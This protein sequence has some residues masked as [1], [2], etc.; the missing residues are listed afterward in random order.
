MFSY[1]FFTFIDFLFLFSFLFFRIYFVALL[2]NYLVNVIF[3]FF[4]QFFKNL[5]LNVYKLYKMFFSFKVTTKYWLYSPRY[6]TYSFLLAKCFIHW[7]SFLQHKDVRRQVFGEVIMIKWGHDG[8]AI[9]NRIW[10]LTELL[11]KFPPL[12]ALCNVK[13]Q[14]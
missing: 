5:L 1:V 7:D 6:I 12:S 13:I 14:W 10:I 4:K 8:G 2:Y 11:E 3:K 9:M